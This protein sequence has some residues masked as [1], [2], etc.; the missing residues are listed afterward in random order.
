MSLKETSTLIAESRKIIEAG[1]DDSVSLLNMILQIVTNI[2]TRMKRMETNIDK[3]IDELKQYMLS[4]SAR[5]RELETL[6]KDMKMKVS[7]C[8][9]SC[10]GVSNLFDKIEEQTKKVENQTK[11]N[12]RNLIQQD[13]RIKKLEEQPRVQTVVQPAVV[14][15]EIES[16]KS[17]VLDLQCH[18]MKNN[19]VFSGLRSNKFENCENKLRD[20]IRHEFRID[21]YIFKL[22]MSIVLV[23]L[24]EMAPV[25]L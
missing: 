21:H 23:S 8:E 5:V 9:S 6:T 13:T 16:L 18:S 22:E 25:P 11:L 1:Q 17:K 24:V 2:D 14:S 19:L 3:R 20:F 7:E 10:N 15:E 12:T 4:V